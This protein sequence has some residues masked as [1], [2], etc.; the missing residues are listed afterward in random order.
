MAHGRFCKLTTAPKDADYLPY[1]EHC[2]IGEDDFLVMKDYNH[3]LQRG[4]AAGGNTDDTAV[5]GE[6]HGG[7]TPEEAIVPVVVISRTHAPVTITYTLPDT[8]KRSGGKACVDILF[9][10]DV[11]S[12]EVDTTCGKCRC[13]KD[14]N[15]KTW[16]LYFTELNGEN[17]TLSIYA[18]GKILPHKNVRIT[19]SGIG[20]GSMGGLP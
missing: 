18:N 2:R 10:D 8:L 4:N 17:A 3:Y 19:T 13:E 12:L 9:S 14:N 15:S 7:Y 6:L 16:K 11:Y 1:V 20:K 5:A